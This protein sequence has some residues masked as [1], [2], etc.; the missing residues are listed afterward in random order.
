MKK[1]LSFIVLF[2]FT[3]G[4]AYG[5]ER[6]VKI[7]FESSSFLNTPSIPFDKPFGIIGEAGKEVELVKVNISYEG[8]DYILHKFVWNRLEGNT[9]ETF[10]IVV[11]AILKSNTK[12]DFEI[13]TYKLLSSNQKETLLNNVEER[14][15]FLLSNNIYFDGKNVVVNKPKNVY[16]Q[17]GQLIRESFQYHESKNLL[18]IEAPTSLVLQ[19]LKNQ[20]KFKFGRFLRRESNTEK[21]E[22]SSQLIYEK[23]DHLVELVKSELAPFINSQI[24]QH[25]R[26]VNIKSIETD[27]EPFTLPINVG[28]Y[29]WSKSIDIDNREIKNVNFTP[30]AGLTIPFNNKSK[31]ASNSRMFDSFGYSAG[32]LFQPI[33]DANGTEYTTPGV[34]LPVYTGIGFRMFKVIRLN[35]GGIIL[36]EKGSQNF[37]KLSVI[38]TVGMSL[39]LNLWLGIKK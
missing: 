5:Q 23:I 21:D 3:L 24:V 33:K 4:L 25:H 27:K 30:G 19:E 36:G 17:L 9:S 16:E 13:V 37:K 29:A 32:V 34:D 35:V 12:Y 15:R 2:I 28:M 8:K 6:V 22:I 14:V 7:D 10:N 31:L 26:K 1:H 20:S 39:E 18:E 38:P 11:P